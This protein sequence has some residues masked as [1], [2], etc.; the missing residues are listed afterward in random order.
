LKILF[1]NL[2]ALKFTVVT[3]YYAPL[4]GSESALCYLAL[5]LAWRGHDVSLTS[6]LPDDQGG[7]I[8]N[9][10]H[11]PLDIVKDTTFFLTEKFDAIVI[12]NAPA[13]AAPLKSMSPQSRILFWSHV[14]PDQP[15]MQIL[16]L[17]EQGMQARKA[18][19]A[20]IFVSNW[21]RLEVERAFGAFRKAMVIGNGIAPAF[22]NMF[23]S[24]VDIL[25]AKQNR[26]AYTATPYRGLSVLVRAMEGLDRDTRLDLFSSMRVY[27]SGDDEFAPLFRQAA[28]NIAIIDHGSVSQNELAQHLHANAFLFYP[29]IYHETFCITAAEAMAAGMRVVTTR[30]GALEE[31]TM[32]LA[33]LVPVLTDD[34]N[35]LVQTF[36]EAMRRIIDQFTAN[37]HAWA[38][39][40]F[41]QSEIVNQTYNW[42]AR[43]LLWEKVLG[44]AF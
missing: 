22:E 44:G 23:A 32:G 24:S 11:Y 5:Q 28:H 42:K 41:A 17:P 38:E 4:G 29:S 14:L 34:G 6:N 33:E 39:A 36:R 10:C 9:I 21:Q 18:I 30:L 16:A 35:T 15:S 25:R 8:G 19:D 12:C 20:A 13:A 43:A 37:P 26:A 27:Q 40:M 2:S 1:V 7:M 31:T 3:P